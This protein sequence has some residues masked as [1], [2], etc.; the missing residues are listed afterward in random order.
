MDQKEWAE[1]DYYAD[2]GVSSSA[3]ADEIR[4]A[5]RKLARENH[6]DLKP[7]D[8]EAEERFKRA[9]EA[10]DVVGDEKKRKQYDEF[11]RMLQNGGLGGSGFPGGF[12]RTSG[13]GQG[14]SASDIFG[15]QAGQG[16]F[17]DLFGD[18][19]GGAGGP[20]RQARPRRGA[21]IETRITISF[22]EAAQGTQIPVQL[23]GEA[24][25][26]RCHGSGSASGQ[27]AT[28]QSCDGTGY[29]SENRGAFG[30]SRPCPD[31]G[32]T[33]ERVT[34]PCSNCR[35]TGTETRSRT[36][37]V[38][39]PAGVAD[40]QR[41]RLAGRGEAG[42]NGKPSGDLFVTVEVTAD[43]LFRRS[44]DNL[45]VTVPVSFADLALGGT[46][47]APTLEDTVR[48][49]VPAGTR[50]GKTFRVRGQGI[51]NGDLLVTVKVAVPEKLSDEAAEALKA[52][53]RAERESGFDPRAGWEGA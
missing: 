38:R 23:T 32:G 14:F 19:F 25:C 37:T 31:C 52:Y 28:C 13:Q 7:D 29:Q 39:I 18:I 49:K 10:Y 48:L 50:D 41:L 9:A 1:K 3:S 42:P 53:A 47:S 45:E 34:D 43:P 17:S 15:Q 26:Q 8:K 4:K 12:R 20:R 21:D 24:P 51:K 30:F 40:G 44:G 36:I 16:G 35:G 27:A 5:Y 2:L 11:R 33:G 22:R 6:P 46:I